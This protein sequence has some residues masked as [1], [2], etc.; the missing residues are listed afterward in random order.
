MIPCVSRREK[1][2]LRH[3]NS[4]E[5]KNCLVLQILVQILNCVALKFSGHVK[6]HSAI[7]QN[8]L[9]QHQATTARKK[10]EK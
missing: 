3:N 9:T 5:I 1:V 7:S 10:Q 8:Q 4:A 6:K 2:M